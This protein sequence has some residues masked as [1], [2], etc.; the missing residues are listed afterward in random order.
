[1]HALMITGFDGLLLAIQELIIEIA[2]R[3]LILIV[4]FMFKF[5]EG[6]KGRGYCDDGVI[7][8]QS[9]VWTIAHSSKHDVH[10]TREKFSKQFRSF[11]ISLLTL[12]LSSHSL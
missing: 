4:Q 10:N 3:R 1:M 8:C 6:E 2:L 9:C 11:L 12:R 7:S 5:F